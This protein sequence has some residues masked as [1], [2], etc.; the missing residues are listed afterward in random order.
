MLLQ[1]SS[2]NLFDHSGHV[3][4]A[5]Q[6]R[7][8]RSPISVQPPQHSC[9][10]EIYSNSATSLTPYGYNTCPRHFKHSDISTGACGSKNHPAHHPRDQLA[11][12]HI[13]D[14]KPGYNNHTGNSRNNHIELRRDTNKCDWPLA[15]ADQLLIHVSEPETAQLQNGD[16]YFYVTQSADDQNLQLVLRHV[17][18]GKTLQEHVISDAQ[19]REVFADMEDI[20]ADLDKCSDD[21]ISAL[22]SKCVLAAESG[23]A[24]MSW[25]D[26]KLSVRDAHERH[27][28]INFRFIPKAR[29]SFD[30]SKEKLKN[31]GE[32]CVRNA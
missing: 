10:R 18:N 4:T 1:I 6:D 28:A 19:R 23:V 25:R 32:E 14:N 15:A 20:A 29:T 7:Q 30:E 24:R 13:Y 2:K 22:L 27:S 26:V 11:Y 17:T 3:V 8:V 31:T 12:N 5:D 21:K 9:A 16:S